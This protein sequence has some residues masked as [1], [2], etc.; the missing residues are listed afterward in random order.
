MADSFL[1]CKNVV[2]GYLDAP[3]IKGVSIEVKQ[4]E[5]VAILGPNGSGKSTL[6]K[7][8]I[9]LVKLFSGE[10]YFDGKRI[11]G[12]DTSALVERGIATCLQGKRVFPRLTVEENLWMGAYTIDKEKYR[13][14]LAEVRSMFPFLEEK[15]KLF[16]GNLSGGEQEILTFARAMLTN[17]K[18]I[19]VDEPSIG[20]SPKFV[21]SIYE[22]LQKVNDLGIAILLVEQ[23]VRKALEV[24]DR[25][26]VL[27]TGEKK[28]E[29][30]PDELNKKEDLAAMYLGIKP[31]S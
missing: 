6:L 30:T 7:S 10:I 23:N 26:Y 19:L 20:L 5:L 28:F 24:A 14:K 25:V 12:L 3:I 16:A 15:R 22:K 21:L 4:G 17:P 1:E 31:E 2:A 8:I 13:T 18:I 27:D 29:G 9:G 11:D